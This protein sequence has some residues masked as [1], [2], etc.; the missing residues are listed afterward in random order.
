MR[1]FASLF[2]IWAATRRIVINLVRSLKRLSYVI[3][4]SHGWGLCARVR[5]RSYFST[6]GMAGHI[7]LKFGVPLVTH[8]LCILQKSWVGHQACSNLPKLDPGSN[9]IFSVREPRSP[10]S[11]GYIAVAG[12]KVSRIPGENESVRSKIPQ[13]FGSWI[14]GIQDLGCFWILAHVCRAY[15]HVRMFSVS[16]KPLG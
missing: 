5:M 9:K 14:L 16:R 13:D 2:S 6:S 8:K 1:T 7:A 15:L 4:V 3:F 12:S 11:H 10:I